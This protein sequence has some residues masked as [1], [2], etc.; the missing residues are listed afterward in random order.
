V[1]WQ[2]KSRLPFLR[3]RVR[4]SELNLLLLNVAGLRSKVATSVHGVL[5]PLTRK[6]ETLGGSDTNV[7]LRVLL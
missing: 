1:R 5:T 7:R 4:V 6:V 3:V 2:G